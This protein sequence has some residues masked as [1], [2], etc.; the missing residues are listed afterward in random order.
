[1]YL[2]VRFKSV[3]NDKQRQTTE[4]PILLDP[5]TAFNTIILKKKDEVYEFHIFIFEN[6]VHK[7]ITEPHQ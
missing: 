4:I 7:Q 5:F 1:M 2:K 6:K 3:D